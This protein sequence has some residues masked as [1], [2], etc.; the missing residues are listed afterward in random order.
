MERYQYF[1]FISYSRKDEKWA[2]W[3]QKNLE[4]YRLPNIIRKESEVLL[5]KQI[6]PVFR[7][8]T[9]IGIGS[10][11]QT[12][13]K[14]LEDSKYLIVICSPSS[15]QSEWVNHEIEAFIQLGRKDQII[16]FIVEGVPEKADPSI[17]C[18]PP[19][20]DKD[21]LGASIS[22]LGK[23]KALVK[24]IAAIL[25][26]KFDKLWDRHKRVERKKKLTLWAAAGLI[27]IASALAGF[28][29]WDYYVP[30]Y[31]YYADY[32]D[33]WGIPSGIL[34]LSEQDI[35]A[36]MG[37]Y[38]FVYKKGKLRSVSYLNSA[39]KPIEYLIEEYRK[40][41]IIQNLFYEEETGKLNKIEVLN[42]NLHVIQMFMISGQSSEIID[43]KTPQGWNDAL[44]AN[45][46]EIPDVNIY[47]NNSNNAIKSK[48]SR[49]IVTRNSDGN[50]IEEKYMLDNWNTPQADINGIYGTKFTLDSVGRIASKIYLNKNG[51]RYSD[52]RGISQ[53]KYQY[54]DNGFF[55]ETSYFDIRDSLTQN[56]DG[57]ARIVLD[58]YDGNNITEFYYN[59]R[60]QLDYN[61]YGVAIVDYSFSREGFL[62]NIAYFDVNRQPILNSALIHKM[63]FT[64]NHNG[65]IT[66]IQSFDTKDSL[67]V[68]ADKYY[69]WNAQYDSKGNIIEKKYFD[70]NK[71]LTLN[72]DGVAVDSLKYNSYGNL[73]E[74]KHFDTNFQRCLNKDG[75]S[76]MTRIFNNKNYCISET[77]Y[78]ENDSLTF[79][80]GRY[81][82]VTYEYD[83]RG[84]LVNESFFDTHQNLVVSKDGYASV[85]LTYN[86][87]G[88]K[89]RQ[90]FLDNEL[91]PCKDNLGV[92]AFTIEY[93]ERGNK[94]AYKYFD[95]ENQPCNNING[96]AS[97]TAKYDEYGNIIEVK[98][99]DKNGNPCLFKNQY[100]KLVM[101]YDLYGNRTSESFFDGKSKQL[102]SGKV[103]YNKSGLV[104]RKSFYGSRNEPINDQNGVHAYLYEYDEKLNLIRESFFNSNYQPTV[105]I[106]GFAAVEHEYNAIRQRI[107]TTLYNK[108]G[109][110]T[111]LHNGVAKEVYI[112]DET[113]TKVQIE[114]YDIH[115]K[116]IDNIIQNK[117]TAKDVKV[118]IPFISKVYEGYSGEKQGVF[119]NTILLKYGSWDIKNNLAN[120][121]DGIIKS[122]SH[123][124]KHMV[125]LDENGVFHEFILP[126]GIAGILFDYLTIDGP[127]YATII[128]AYKNFEKN[129][130]VSQTN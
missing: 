93:D 48:I 45:S 8:K 103:T 120:E 82:K 89:V 109:Q 41:P 19:A 23:E 39:N 14:E 58:I 18:F 53:I 122:I 98:Y 126:P 44:V 55:S 40:R 15:A 69:Y 57:Y 31:K 47:G 51:I 20:L 13:R 117:Q 27:I 66:Q 25:N 11:T 110:K 121:L 1:A 81:A 119:Q 68:T 50:I 129:K 38:A 102:Y 10:L 42:K 61:K 83:D 9:D 107:S 88:Q 43:I 24:T 34:E 33:R 86:N 123:Q 28:S 35:K 111:S 130:S 63:A 54:H 97:Y 104:Y 91:N 127:T 37:H 75:I 96:I 56:V 72:G 92:A 125:I 21:I 108:E 76:R 99:F 26:L 128:D 52:K 17:N 112:Y 106:N 46:V 60:N 73:I 78:D 49:V 3:L 32:V 67:I 7:D 12:L 59:T 77:Y 22:E 29:F 85:K 36:R 6:R 62:T 16:P 115:G 74:V 79:Y 116:K 100:H 84:N 87:S 114:Y 30:K 94:S 124:E 105:S 64:N 101:T 80:Q 113:G 2:K 65:F 70:K 95:E 90:E 118:R 71:Q 4:N 5:P